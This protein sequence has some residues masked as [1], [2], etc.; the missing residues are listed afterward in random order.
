ML[1]AWNVTKLFRTDILKNTFGQILLIGIF[2]FFFSL[3][4]VLFWYY[5]VV[6]ASKNQPILKVA[7]V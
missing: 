5:T 7:Y 6:E 4:F 1:K 3:D 2:R